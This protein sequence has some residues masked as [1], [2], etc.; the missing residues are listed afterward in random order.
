[1]LSDNSV[2]QARFLSASANRRDPDATQVVDS[3]R[4]ER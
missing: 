3:L 4:D 1:M 2:R